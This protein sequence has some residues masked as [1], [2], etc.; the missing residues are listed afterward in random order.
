LTGT[1][2]SL[3]RANV[4]VGEGMAAPLTNNVHYSGLTLALDLND[5]ATR[6][7]A[8]AAGMFWMRRTATAAQSFNFAYQRPS[9]RGACSVTG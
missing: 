5:D 4:I 7:E 3:A 6:D 9:Q 1:R 2:H 8:N